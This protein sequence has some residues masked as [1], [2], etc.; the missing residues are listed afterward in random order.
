MLP[1]K[2]LSSLHKSASWLFAVP[3]ALY[4]L[5]NRLVF[6]ALHFIS[7]PEYQLLNNMKLFTTSLV[8][9]VVMKRQLRVFQWLALL[10]L[11]LGMALATTPKPGSTTQEASRAGPGGAVRIPLDT[12]SAVAGVMNEWLIKSSSSVLEANVWLYLFGALI[13]LASLLGS[14]GETAAEGYLAGFD[15]SMLPWSVV[16]CNAV[17]GQSIAF[18]FR[19]ADS[20]VKLYAVCAAMALTAI[21]SSIFLSYSLDFHTLGGYLVTFLS[22]C[23]YY[24]PPDVLFSSDTDFFHG[25]THTRKTQ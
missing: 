25:L 14:W 18:L 16:L 24:L 9:R 12:C 3:A 2:A 1:P 19:Y 21:L 10:L 6:E 13:T 8:F 11:G 22:M 20:I 4:T 7:P 23:L 15:S 17:L 5:Q